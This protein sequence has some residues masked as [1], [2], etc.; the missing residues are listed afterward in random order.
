VEK[1]KGK[2]TRKAVFQKYSG[3]SVK[4]RRGSGEEE[5][6]MWEGGESFTSSLG[7]EEKSIPIRK[8]NKRSR[9]KKAGFKI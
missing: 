1:G 5:P 6:V 9:K 2:K 3:V 8:E 4:V 7:I